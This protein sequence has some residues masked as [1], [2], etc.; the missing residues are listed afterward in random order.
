MSQFQLGLHLI[1][2]FL[3]YFLLLDCFFLF[4]FS[5]ANLRSNNAGGGPADFGGPVDS[6]AAAAGEL[7]KAETSFTS[8]C[9]SSMASSASGRAARRL[10]APAPPLT[11]A[12][13]GI[14]DQFK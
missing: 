8:A 5:F 10:A 4:V 6:P 11:F 3:H 1:Y 2:F 7:S 14:L 13:G 12:F 9:E